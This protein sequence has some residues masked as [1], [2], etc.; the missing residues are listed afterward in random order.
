MALLVPLVADQP[1]CFK[2]SWRTNWSAFFPSVW[3]QHGDV[4]GTWDEKLLWSQSDKN[5]REREGGKELGCVC[6]CVGPSG[7]IVWR[8]SNWPDP[9]CIIW[10]L[11][12]EQEQ[13]RQRL[14]VAELL[15]STHR[16]CCFYWKSE[17]QN[18]TE[19]TQWFRFKSCF[20]ALMQ[21]WK[22]QSGFW[23]R[24]QRE[25]R[26]H[27]ENVLMKCKKVTNCTTIQTNWYKALI[28]GFLKSVNSFK[29]IFLR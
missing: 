11:D 22:R 3:P 25:Q 13:W 6:V 17:G 24:T 16:N 29:H 21:R 20:S 4:Q 27:A 7:L 23:R 2:L 5:N 9:F 1:F 14:C 15:Q 8:F 19:L 28:Y 12:M 18:K 26:L 10:P